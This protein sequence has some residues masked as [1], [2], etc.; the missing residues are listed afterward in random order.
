MPIAL[1]I[2]LAFSFSAAVAPVAEL[3]WLKFSPLILAFVIT[4][5]EALSRKTER[6]WLHRFLVPVLSATALVASCRIVWSNDKS[7]R[8]SKTNQNLHFERI[9]GR[10]GDEEATKRYLDA[11][12]NLTRQLTAAKTGTSVEKFFSSQSERQ[13]L[14]DEVNQANQKLLLSHEIRMNPVRDYVLAKFDAWVSEIQRRGIKVQLTS[15]DAP[16]IVLASGPWRI[17]RIAVFESGD[18]AQLQIYPALISDGRVTGGLICAMNFTSNRGGGDTTVF[19][20]NVDEKQ[21]RISPTRPRFTY[22]DYTGTLENPIED[23]DFVASLDEA[24]DQAMAFVV[25]EATA[26]R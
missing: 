6:K 3:P 10:L 26:T 19:Q 4:L 9:E 22:K 5:C 23:K 11:V 13:K 14:R 15:V 8:E 18:R 7:A 24:L 25:E 1:Q 12:G 16:A 17:P 21:Y 20:M 2:S